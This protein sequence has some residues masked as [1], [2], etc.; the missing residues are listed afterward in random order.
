MS[1]GKPPEKVI[2]IKWKIVY[3]YVVL[4]SYCILIC[5]LFSPCDP[6]RCTTYFCLTAHQLRT[7]VK[8]KNKI[9]NVDK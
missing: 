6:F 8:N 3:D 2:L 4:F 9:I 7:T 5:L 1:D